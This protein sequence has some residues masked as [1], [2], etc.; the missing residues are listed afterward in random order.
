MIV[1]KD[2]PKPEAPPP[3]ITVE[4]DASWIEEWCAFGMKEIN[5]SLAK[6]AD[7]EVFYEKWGH[8]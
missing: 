5:E 7:F 2:K 4:V 1:A 6:H 3:A 8:V